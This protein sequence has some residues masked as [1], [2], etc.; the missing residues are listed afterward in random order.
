MT[1][2]AAFAA[3]LL[4]RFWR[5]ILAAVSAMAAYLRGRHDAKAKAK[6]EDDEHAR[7]ALEDALRLDRGLDRLPPDER[8]RRVRRWERD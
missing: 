2:L 5:P 3:E 6:A 7:A 4:I 8:E 1:W